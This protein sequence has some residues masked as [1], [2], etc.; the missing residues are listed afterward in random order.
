MMNCNPKAGQCEQVRIT[1]SRIF[2]TRKQTHSTS[3]EKISD[4]CSSPADILAFLVL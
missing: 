1:S 2:A 3:I 4:P